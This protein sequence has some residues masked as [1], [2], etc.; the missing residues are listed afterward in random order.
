MVFATDLRIIEG[1]GILEDVVDTFWDKFEL[2][3]MY[4]YPYD[5]FP[6]RF[7]KPLLH[8]INYYYYGINPKSKVH[9]IYNPE[10]KILEVYFKWFGEY[11]ER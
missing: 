4:R 8:G 10:D 7:E 3:K 9:W 2:L 5:D 1:E 11:E 6:M